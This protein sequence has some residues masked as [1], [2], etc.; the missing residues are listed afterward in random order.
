MPGEAKFPQKI[1]DTLPMP[2]TRLYDSETPNSAVFPAVNQAWDS[3]VADFDNNGRPDVFLLSGAQLR[4]STV[5]QSGS[6]HLEAQLAGGTKGF[7][8]VTAGTVR[9]MVD[10]ESFGRGGCVRRDPCPARL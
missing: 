7:Q 9:F 6:T 5:L 10:M 3:V 1:Y 8:M 4:P 2:W